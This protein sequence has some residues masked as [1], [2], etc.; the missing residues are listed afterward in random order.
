MPRTLAFS[1][2]F[3]LSACTS[4]PE[5]GG[6]PPTDSGPILDSAD[7]ACEAAVRF[8]DHDGDGHGDPATE[9]STCDDLGTESGDDCD[10]TNGNIHPDATEICNFV[11]DDCSGEVDGSD[12]IDAAQLYA[13]ADR[14]GYGDA[15]NPILAC[16]TSRGV[17]ANSTDCDDTTAAVSPAATERCDDRDNDC[18]GESDEVGSTGES[19]WFPDADGDRA[20]SDNLGE[21]VAACSAPAGYVDN[22]D[23]CNDGDAAISPFEAELCDEIDNNCD[24][25]I[26]ESGAR[27]ETVWYADLDGDGYGNATNS[28][29]ACEM[30]AGYTT[31]TTDCDDSRSAIHPGGTE[32]CDEADADEDCD[33]LA[34]EA[35]PDLV[36]SGTWYADVDGDGAGD[37]STSLTTTCAPSGWVE[38]AQDCDDADPE[39]GPW[40]G[41]TCDDTFDRNC[42]GY[43]GT[44]DHDADGVVACEDCNDGDAAV[45]PAAGEL[46]NGY[47]DDCDLLVDE[48]V[49]DVRIVS[50]TEAEAFCANYGSV[51]GS[52]DIE[53]LTALNELSCLQAVS[54]HLRF[55]GVRAASMS[56][57]ES[58]RWVGGDLLIG[59]WQAETGVLPPS[60]FSSLAGL[61]RLRSVGRNLWVAENSVSELGGLFRLDGVGGNV[62]LLDAP[63]TV[64]NL[65][66]TSIGDGLWLE[67]LPELSE[68][69]LSDL[70]TFEGSLWFS[71][72]ATASGGFGIDW[73]LPISGAL[74]LY[75]LSA[76]ANA[77][78]SLPSSLGSLYVEETELLTLTGLESTTAVLGNVVIANND[79]LTDLAALDSIRNI[80]GDLA[81]SNNASLGGWDDFP[82]LETVGGTV[83]LA[84][85]GPSSADGFGALTQVGVGLEVQSATTLTR[86]DGFTALEHCPSLILNIA[87]NLA[88]AD[89][90]KGVPFEEN[91]TANEVDALVDLDFLSGVTALSGTLL[92]KGNG[93]MTSLAGLSALES[94]DGALTI[95][96]NSVLASASIPTLTS[97]GGALSFRKLP[98][99]ASINLDSLA[100]VEGD[101]ALYDLPALADLSGFRSLS[102]VGGLY[103]REVDSL[104]DLSGLDAL[105][106][107]DGSL[108]LLHQATL[109]HL[110]GLEGLISVGGDF[111]IAYNDAL[112]DLSGLDNLE[113]IGED[114]TISSNDLLVQPN[115]LS[116]LKTIG[117]D[118][119]VESNYALEDFSGMGDFTVGNTVYLYGNS[120]LS[121]LSGLDGLTT[122][123]HHFV[124]YQNDALTDLA[125]LAQLSTVGE[126]FRITGCDA[127]SSFSGLDSLESVGGSFEI[128]VQSEWGYGDGNGSLLTMDGLD[129]LRTVGDQFT[130]LDNPLL[131]EIDALAG[132]ESVGGD[133]AVVGNTSLPAAN[134]EQLGDG[135]PTVGGTVTIRDNL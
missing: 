21:A 4:D 23:D 134:A 17:V 65:P 1:V 109:A 126:D 5:P 88:S 45:F 90:L 105:A 9:F 66:V 2:V 76:D 124:L 121:S 123:P 80:G 35:D 46:S 99:L 131:L 77:G 83:L 60:S 34:D 69:E 122:I 16:Q 117:H 15:A 93:R 110:N 104:S 130:I 32:V 96:S 78:W 95:E 85:K 89:G 116:S 11:D 22:A 102:S 86:I 61:D 24:G 74:G 92:V 129:A 87:G 53:S 8:L 118:L 48:Y 27:G 47:D 98:L 41:E 36:D 120:A 51:E 30:P 111:R 40:A 42:D 3:L 63:I 107:V 13:D 12:A 20:G 28:L 50:E 75:A 133:L 31:D 94:L 108:I 18:D 6:K 72:V 91:V 79:D 29:A 25:Q 100:E 128:G 132:L 52:L 56:G 59:G 113:S 135:T 19:W 70:S 44:E 26:D 114:L 97:V 82:A 58:L 73:P 68:V 64:V 112:L 38:N 49:G 125:E 54:G 81:L 119:W 55:G 10:D 33:G 127:I 106:T 62:T 37:V 67:D 7:T 115:S 43:F 103:L 57:L 84:G 71:S 39:V 101:L 14:D